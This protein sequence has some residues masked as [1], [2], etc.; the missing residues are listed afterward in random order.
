MY[1]RFNNAISETA[2]SIYNFWERIAFFINEFYPLNANSKAPSYWRYF[3][4]VNKRAAKNSTLRNQVSVGLYLA[5][6]TKKSKNV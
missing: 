3:D 1:P 6:V 4:E 5:W 2:G